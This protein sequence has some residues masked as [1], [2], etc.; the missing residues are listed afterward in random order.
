VVSL[1]VRLCAGDNGSSFII[2]LFS[3]TLQVIVFRYGSDSIDVNAG[4]GLLEMKGES[5]FVAMQ[6]CLCAYTMV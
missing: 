5:N 6:L 1:V 4:F 3:K 2:S